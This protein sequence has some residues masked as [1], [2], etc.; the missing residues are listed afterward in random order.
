MGGE[1]TLMEPES[2]LLERR[3]SNCKPPIFGFHVNFR[4]SI[5]SS[6]FS[7]KLITLQ[8]PHQQHS[9]VSLNF[10]GVFSGYG[11]FGVANVSM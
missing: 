6:P 4:G 8:S 2:T 3:K 11:T 5:L 9:G 1:S 10:M 7:C